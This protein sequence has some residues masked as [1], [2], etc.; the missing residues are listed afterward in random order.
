MINLTPISNK[1]RNLNKLKIP[2]TRILTIVLFTSISIYSQEQLSRTILTPDSFVRGWLDAWNSHNV[3]RILSYYTEDAFFEDVP[4]VENGWDVPLHGQQIIRKSVDSTFKEMPD[5]KF[6]LDST[7]VAGDRMVVEWTMTGTRYRGFTGRFSTRAVSVLALEGDKIVRERDYYDMYQVLSK[8]G[9]IPAL[10]AEQP[11]TGN[12]VQYK[13]ALLERNKEVVQ[14]NT[15]EVW[16]RGNLDILEELYTPDFI[17][18]FIVGPEWRGYKGIRKAVSGHRTSF[19]DWNEQ[20]VDIVAEGDRVAIR[21]R[22]R[23]TQKREF[24]GIPPTGR[25][26]D[27]FEVAIFRLENGRMAEQW[28]FP[29]IMGLR[30]QLTENLIP[31]K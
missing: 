10:E 27:I 4:S 18:H 20:I 19:P 28:G 5:L 11:N 25:K 12:K 9:I 22:S 21:F 6:E 1:P 23:G 17:C 24:N 15:A 14:R 16:N 2:L 7:S 13:P 26:V 29:D 31:E 8:L 30:Q 3:D